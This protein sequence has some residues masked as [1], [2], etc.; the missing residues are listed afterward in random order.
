MISHLQFIYQQAVQLQSYNM[1]VKE[2]STYF[3]NVSGHD[4][5][6]TVATIESVVPG[7]PR[8]GGAPKLKSPMERSST[9]GIEQA[10][11]RFN[12]GN[13]S[14][15]LPQTVQALAK[16]SIET[17]AKLLS[18]YASTIQADLKILGQVNS[19]RDQE[20]QAVLSR[21]YASSDYGSVRLTNKSLDARLQEL[22][23]KIADTAKDYARADAARRHNQGLGV[24]KRLQ[25][26]Q[27][28]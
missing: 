13:P 19:S 22:D 7:T 27:Q 25:N 21:L 16:N 9:V 10:L 20:L 15:D 14:K 24:V 4:T 17:R 18:Q 23:E 11:R 1:A 28:K 5:Q 2:I 12:I 3:K 6:N 8:S 26:L